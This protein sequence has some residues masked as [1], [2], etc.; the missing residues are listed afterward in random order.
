[1]I[2]RHLTAGEL[3]AYVEKRNGG[4]PYMAPSTF[5][6]RTCAPCRERV[7]R[8]ER[9]ADALCDSATREPRREIWPSES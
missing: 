9:L 2:G 7:H 6:W 8:L 5:I 3:E 4:A 1:M